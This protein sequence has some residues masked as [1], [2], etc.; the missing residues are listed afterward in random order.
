MLSSAASSPEPVPSSSSEINV[1]NPLSSAFPWKPGVV[2]RSL[3]RSSVSKVN[4]TG[5]LAP[6]IHPGA[7][8]LAASFASRALSTA[9]ET[10]TNPLST[11]FPGHLVTKEIPRQPKQEVVKDI[12]QN[13]GG[14][15]VVYALGSGENGGAVDRQALTD[16]FKAK[17]VTVGWEIATPQET[18]SL[19]MKS[20]ERRITDLTN[21]SNPSEIQ[22]Q[23]L[24]WCVKIKKQIETEKGEYRPSTYAQDFVRAGNKPQDLLRAEL[25]NCYVDQFVDE[26]GV[27]N[28]FTRF[29][30]ITDPSQSL[31]NFKMLKELHAKREAVNVALKNLESERA[32]QKSEAE[33]HRIEEIQA[34]YQKQLSLE[35]DHRKTRVDQA[36]EEYG[37]KFEEYSNATKE[38]TKEINDLRAK[39]EKKGALTP[40]Q[41]ETFEKACEI[42]E[43]PS[44]L[45]SELI[46]RKI[47][48]Q[49][50]ALHFVNIQV[51][52]HPK[53]VA[54]GMLEVF[55]LSL[56]HPGNRKV[57]KNGLAHCEDNEM[58]DEAEILQEFSGKNFI[59]EEGLDA[60]Y[61]DH[62]GRFHL[63]KPEGVSLNEVRVDIYFANAVMQREVAGEKAKTL[64]RNINS[65][66]LEMMEERL[67][68]K[69]RLDV[70]GSRE[71]CLRFE[72]C[73]RAIL[74]GKVSYRIGEDIIACVRY[75]ALNLSVNCHSGKDRTGFVSFRAIHRIASEAVDAR[76]KEGEITEKLGEEIKDSLGE[77]VLDAQSIPRKI[78]QA[79]GGQRY[80][81]IFSLRPPGLERF[82]RRIRA[83]A[84]MALSR[85]DQWKKKTPR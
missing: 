38:Y 2:N 12:G 21:L 1:E 57:E 56:L 72:K 59:L 52:E 66:F 48:L 42:L 64:I 63:Q 77:K 15:Q 60:P 75:L 58:L 7:E 27:K 84:Q 65:R 33:F 25:S 17:N 19:T 14:D 79:N 76:V 3:P 74:S 70:P 85:L 34:P 6:D 69:F 28:A 62:E 67:G 31:L 61:I 29:G 32:L 20:L 22:K 41:R 55:Q 11:N 49:Q 43:T 39:Q 71:M 9:I 45:D 26:K 81:K 83:L 54:L 30:V 16:E 24:D 50:Q 10:V 68:N 51:R 5:V 4:D 18:K 80:L 47:L 82:D 37:R 46:K 73:R 36:M 53:D 23:E 8:S 13:V 78:T 40:P 44:K 35:E